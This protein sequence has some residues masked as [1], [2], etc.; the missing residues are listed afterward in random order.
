LLNLAWRMDW[1]LAKVIGTQRKI[2]K[3]GANSI[4]NK[5]LISNEKIISYLNYSFQKIDEYLTIIAEDFKKA[6]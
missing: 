6:N 1:L 2:S 4:Q 5:D 3:Q